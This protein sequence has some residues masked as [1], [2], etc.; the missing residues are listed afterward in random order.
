MKIKACRSCGSLGIEVFL[1]LG[2]SPLADRLLSENKLNE[3][4]PSFPLEVAYCHKCSLVQILETVDP[5]ILFCNDYPYYSSVIASLLKHSR[6]N[7]LEL[8]AS[9]RLD[10][11]SLVIELASNDGYLLKNYIEKGIPCL[12]IDPASGPAEAARKVGVPTLCT[13]FTAE[14]GRKLAAEEKKAD[15]IHANN[16]L[17]HVADTH[18]FVSGISELLKEDGVAVIEVPYLKDLIDHCEFDTIYHQHLCYFSVTALDHLFRSHGLFLN[19]VRHLDIH[20]GSLR[21]YVEKKERPGSVLG[22]LE[23]ER[24]AGV[25]Q[26]SYYRNFAAR[27][28]EVKTALKALLKDLK[29]QGKRIA[30]YGAAAKGCTLLNFAGI[31]R[32]IVEYVVDLNPHKQGKYMTGTHQPIFAPSRLLDDKPDYVLILPW[33]FKDEI[34]SQQQAYQASGGRFIIPIPKPTII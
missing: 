20:G 24:K 12:G 4:E 18:G 31:G 5:E 19:E 6:E 14:L 28:N 9:R 22:F 21:L 16:V 34:M 8:A 25:N 17:A 2:R 32:D 27:V 23:Q 10:S 1:D 11:R 3:P 33:N 15:V 30:G 26:F 29:S 7:A 13:F